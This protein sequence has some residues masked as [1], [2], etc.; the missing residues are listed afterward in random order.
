MNTFNDN[1]LIGNHEL[2]FTQKNN[3]NGVPEFVGGG[4]KIKSF[5]LQGG[6]PIMTTLNDK[7]NR[8]DE[9]QDGGKVTTPFEN[10]AIPAGLFY[11]NQRFTKRDTETVNT[12]KKHEMLP[13]DIFDKL[14]GLVE[15]DKKI[16]RKTRKNIHNLN[17]KIKNKSRR[18][19]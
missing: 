10:L 6:Q 14:F 4:Y 11:I 17:K 1:N 12:Y 7:V 9:M 18:Q 5:F 3:E 8:F 15:Q 2:V 16:K 13:D 19:K